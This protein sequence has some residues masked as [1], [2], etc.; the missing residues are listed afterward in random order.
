MVTQKNVTRSY[1][2]NERLI[3]TILDVAIFLHYTLMLYTLAVVDRDI[4]VV[5]A[6][7]KY[8]T[9]VN[10]RSCP[11]TFYYAG[12]RFDFRRIRASPMGE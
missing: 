5:R 11:L 2:T 7:T 10:G 4:F 12:K 6:A 1:T 3:C 9:N 8:R